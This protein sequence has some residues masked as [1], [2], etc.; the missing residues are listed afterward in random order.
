[1]IAVLRDI[2]AD[3]MNTSLHMSN[4]VVIGRTTNVTTC[5]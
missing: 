2:N 5:A 3:S 4:C 1:M